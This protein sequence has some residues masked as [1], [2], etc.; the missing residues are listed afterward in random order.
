M[1]KLQHINLEDKPPLFTVEDIE[2]RSFVIDEDDGEIHRG[3]V[4]DVIKTRD[5]VVTAI[6]QIGDGK[7]VYKE[8]MDYHDL[9]YLLHWQAEA[10]TNG[11]IT[12]LPFNRISGHKQVSP[13]SEDYAGSKCN[14]KVE[15]SGGFVT[16]K[17]LE[18]VVKDD[19]WTVAK[20]AIDNEL[21]ETLG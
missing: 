13:A 18:I 10:E 19:P 11:E 7:K 20:H 12:F 4:K 15:W 14:L 16:C 2:G 3:I 6:A 9:C 17:L 5:G 21:T 8:R 1:R